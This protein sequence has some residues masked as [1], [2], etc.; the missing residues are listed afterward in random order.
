[1]RI[2]RLII[3]F[4][5]AC[6]TPTTAQTSTT[7]PVDAGTETVSLCTLAERQL[8]KVCPE[9]SKTP[10]QKSFTDFCVETQKNGVK[11]DTH[12]IATAKNC[13]EANSCR[14]K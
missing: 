14:S 3:L 1:M 9:L 10:G 4:M 6:A 11:L 13:D 8:I 12:C 7:D 2:L 5:A